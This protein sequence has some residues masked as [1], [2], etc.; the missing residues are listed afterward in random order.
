MKKTI[1]QLFRV[2]TDGMCHFIQGLRIALWSVPNFFED[3][4]G[5]FGFLCYIPALLTNRI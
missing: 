5:A 4:S 1:P 2:Q 3:F